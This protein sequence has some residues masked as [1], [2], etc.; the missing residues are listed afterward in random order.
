[1]VLR[2]GRSGLPVEDGE[3]GGKKGKK[4]GLLK[5]KN[6]ETKV[7]AKKSKKAVE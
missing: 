2:K 7:K 6:G 1:M 3:S 5:L 4:S